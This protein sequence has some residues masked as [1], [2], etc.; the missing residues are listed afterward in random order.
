[1]LNQPAK[2]S[3]EA[4]FLNV[5]VSDY[6][7]P[8]N[9]KIV[10]VNGIAA[11]T[12]NATGYMRVLTQAE[13]YAL[14]EQAVKRQ[15]DAKRQAEERRQADIRRQEE[16]ARQAEVQKQADIRR[17][18]ENQ[19]RA[20]ANPFVINGGTITEYRGSSKEVII[21]SQVGNSR[22][23]KIGKDAFSRKGLTSVTIPDSVTS[24]G[25]SAFSGN[26]LT[27]VTIPNSITKIGDYAFDG[28]I[29][30]TRITFGK[31]FTIGHSSF[32]NYFEDTYLS[33]LGL[34]GTY[35]WNGRRW[36]RR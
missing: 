8:L 26:N 6:T 32:P 30:L 24:I 17:Q 29:N 15:E 14:P 35:T 7:P 34:P 22:V 16:A 13:H 12:A 1:M 25:E 5:N 9:V 33:L 2:A 18:E 21:P 10:S 28:N 23:T 11:E 36:I 20:E 3:R 27:S 4:R 19:R 31:R